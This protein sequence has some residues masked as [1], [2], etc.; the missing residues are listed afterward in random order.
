M[1]SSP[2]VAPAAHSFAT[3][4]RIDQRFLCACPALRRLD[5]CS[6]AHVD[7]LNVFDFLAHHQLESLARPDTGELATAATDG[8][9][10]V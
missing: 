6:M 8:S 5:L 9:Y 7:R 4:T 3:V 1:G 10:G 2:L